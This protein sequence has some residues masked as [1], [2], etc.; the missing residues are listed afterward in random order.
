MPGGE[1]GDYA[2]RVYA[3]EGDTEINYELD[4]INI[5]DIPFDPDLDLDMRFI[6]LA[7]ICKPPEWSDSTNTCSY[8]RSYGTP[9]A[10]ETSKF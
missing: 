9:S 3:D 4:A 8:G 10:T 5:P 6:K 1:L 2:P 7:S